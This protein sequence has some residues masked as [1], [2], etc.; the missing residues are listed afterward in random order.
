MMTR[1]HDLQDDVNAIDRFREWVLAG[2]LNEEKIVV[3]F[4]EYVMLKMVNYNSIW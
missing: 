1:F 2:L 3:M 4:S